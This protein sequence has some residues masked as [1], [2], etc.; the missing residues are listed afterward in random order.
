MH[1]TPGEGKESLNNDGIVFRVKGKE[2]CFGYMNEI[3]A[4]PGMER[5]ESVLSRYV[6]DIV[7]NATAPDALA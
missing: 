2:I 3:N 6:D 5:F 7:G 4:G 1:R